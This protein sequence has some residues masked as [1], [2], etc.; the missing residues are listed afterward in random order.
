MQNITR[1]VTN[2]KQAQIY[3]YMYPA[4]IE[5]PPQKKSWWSEKMDACKEKCS[6][7]W[8]KK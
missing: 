7:D 6:P 4:C 2:L 8:K 1:C 3:Y 5:E